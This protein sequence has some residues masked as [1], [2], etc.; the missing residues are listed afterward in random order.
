MV[1]VVYEEQ[2]TDIT[3]YSQPLEGTAKDN[4]DRI[5]QLRKAFC[6]PLT[7][8][9]DGSLNAKYFSNDAKE[10]AMNWSDIQMLQL[11]EGIY[12]FGVDS[13]EKWHAIQSHFLPGRDFIEVRLKLTQML[14]T[15]DLG[16]YANTKFTCEKQIADEFAKNKKEAMA[17]GC[18]DEQCGLALKAEVAKLSRA[19][20]KRLEAEELEH[21]KSVIYNNPSYIYRTNATK[22]AKNPN[23]D[24]NSNTNSNSNTKPSSKTVS[25]ATSPKGKPKAKAKA[26]AKSDKKK[27]ATQSN[28]LENYTKR[29]VT[30]QK[31]KAVEEPKPEVEEEE[32]EVVMAEPEPK[33]KQVEKKPK[34]Q[35]TAKSKKRKTGVPELPDSSD[36]EMLCVE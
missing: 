35:P 26:K 10:T 4:F 28:T 19:D 14:G 30:E 21:W 11:L 18:W 7:I 9:K 29:K 15:Q 6:H 1:D 3:W 27:K 22:S 13:A 33:P 16:K 12:Q 17:S 8:N 34:K 36:D 24:S 25:K 31:K 20:V 23:A 2:K 32:D 5:I